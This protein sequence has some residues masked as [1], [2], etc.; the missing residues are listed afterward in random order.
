MQHIPYTLYHVASAEVE[1]G[2]Q[3]IPYT[4]YHVASAEVELGVQIRYSVQ[5]M[6][7]IV[8]A[9]GYWVVV[10]VDYTS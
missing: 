9:D 10:K 8:K 3:H 1:L 4:L 2:V 5:C 7:R 6:Q